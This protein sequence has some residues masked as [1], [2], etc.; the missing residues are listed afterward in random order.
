MDK[1]SAIAG[2]AQPLSHVA[3]QFVLSD[4]AVSVAIPGAKDASQVEQNVAASQRLLLGNDDLSAI[5]A[6]APLE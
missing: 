6:A 2:P 1:L 3:L 4:P 5:K